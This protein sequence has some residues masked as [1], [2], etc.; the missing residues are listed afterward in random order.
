MT[1]K[2]IKI[3]HSREGAAQSPS[4]CDYFLRI[5][6]GF[7]FLHTKKK[8]PEYS[9]CFCIQKQEPAFQA[10]PEELIP[11]LPIVILTL[12]LPFLVDSWTPSACVHTLI[13]TPR[14]HTGQ[15]Q[16]SWLRHLPQECV[17]YTCELFSIGQLCHMVPRLFKQFWLSGNT[18]SI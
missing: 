12:T 16:H 13:L 6:A 10:E 14:T 18:Y 9:S 11:S 4:W 3:R 2:L 8:P 17:L 7:C 15:H 1:G 5:S